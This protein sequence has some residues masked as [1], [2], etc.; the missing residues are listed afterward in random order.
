MLRRLNNEVEGIEWIRLHYAYPHKFPLEII[1]AMAQCE[2][3]CNYLDIPLQHISDPVL[4]R[5]RRLI[6]Q[7]ETEQLILKIRDILPNIALRT[8][9]LVG[10]PGE[11]QQDIDQLAEFIQ[12]IRF[13]RMGIFQYSHEEGTFAGQ[14]YPDD[15]PQEEKAMRANQIMDIQAAISAE[16]NQQKIDNTY[17]VLFDRKESDYFVGR[18]EFDSPEVDNEVLVDAKTQYA[19]IGDFAN[20]TIHEAT[21]FDL[22]GSIGC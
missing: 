4:K 3:V 7:Q 13:E 17:R 22:F 18:T 1:E 21:D 15:V 10:F 14:N 8:T 12:K 11:T 5:M 19:R 16:L 2:K 20:V 9:M 6:T